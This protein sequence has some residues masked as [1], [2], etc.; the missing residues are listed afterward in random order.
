MATYAAVSRARARSEDH[1][2]HRPQRRHVGAAASAWRVADVV[3]RDVGVALGPALG[4]PGGLAVAEQDAAVRGGSAQPEVTSAG[5]GMA[6]Q[7]RHSR[8][9]A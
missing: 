5:S 2:T 1:S 3:E 4:V 9:S 7:S 6:G 8:S